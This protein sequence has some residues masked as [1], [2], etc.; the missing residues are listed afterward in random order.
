MKKALFTILRVAVSLFFIAVLVWTMRDKQGEIISAVK[1]IDRPLFIA[2]GVF[3]LLGIGVISYRL[4]YLLKVQ[5]QS[6]KYREALSLTLV[7]FFFNNFLPTAMGG[8]LVKAYYAANKT[9]DKLGSF[10]TV[11]MDRLFGMFT[12]FLIA[13]TAVMLTRSYSTG[14]ALVLPVFA[15]LII[16]AMLFT[17]L[18][19]KQLARLFISPF[20]RPLRR[21]KF[22]ERLRVEE[23]L[24]RAYN[25]INSFKNS[26]RRIFGVIFISV[27]AQLI[28]FSAIYFWI[29]GMG[30]V[31]PLKNVLIAM[32]LVSI[33]S[34]LP[35][36]NGLG[37]REYGIV[38]LLG[39]AIGKENAFALSLLWLLMLFVISI[40]GG[41][42]YAFGSQ[43]KT[44]I[45]SEVAK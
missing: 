44:K 40:I 9:K 13:A 7:G 6:L 37:V 36:I 2:G 17:L 21:I 26:K 39:S 5:R 43:Y 38:L 25:T 12:L 27:V 29:K 35:S 31:M 3:F 28:S 1:N 22:M 19:N 45:I 33:I 8:D 16:L 42:S 15:V 23:R 41:L 30:E 14:S 18:W 4:K 11:F 24:K 10:A 34:M 20:I 32:P